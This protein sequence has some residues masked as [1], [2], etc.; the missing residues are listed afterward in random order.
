MA[1]KGRAQGGMSGGAR[2][3]AGGK[4]KSVIEM[5][6]SRR[7][8][9]LMV[10]HDEEW[11]QTLIEWITNARE[12]KNFGSLFPLL[13]YILGGAKQEVHHTGQIEHVNIDNARRV[14]RVV[15]GTDS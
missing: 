5:Q 10:L 12:T 11:R 4:K 2:P 14:L 15:G 3:G 7:D 9:V 1:G 13:P 8:T 6:A